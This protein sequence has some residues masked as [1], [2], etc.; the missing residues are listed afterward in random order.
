MQ[1]YQ[2]KIKLNKKIKLQIGK[3][4]EFLLKKKEYTFILVLQKKTLIQELKDIFV[5]S[6]NFIG[7]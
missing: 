5:I 1:S 3:L 7:I 4:G 2:L 6:K